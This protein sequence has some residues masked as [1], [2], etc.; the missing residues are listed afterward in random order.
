MTRPTAVATPVETAAEGRAVAGAVLSIDPPIVYTSLEWPDPMKWV[1][2]FGHTIG[3]RSAAILVY[4]SGHFNGGFPGKLLVTLLRH[5]RRTHPR[6]EVHILCNAPDEVEAFASVGETAMLL[7]HNLAVSNSMFR[8]LPEMETIFD[9]IY[10]ASLS[11]QKRIELAAKIDRVAYVT[12]IAKVPIEETHRILAHLAGLAP[13]HVIVN[14]WQD[15]APARLK[16]A[17]VNVACNRAAV[18]LC[19]SRIEGAM[20]SSMEYLLAGLPIVTTP[21]K[22]GRDL[23]FDPEYCLTVAPNPRAVREAVAALRQRRIKREYIHQ[24]SL[25]KLGPQRRAFLD[26]LDGILERQGYSPRFSGPW[27]WAHRRNFCGYK[28][29]AEH[30]AQASSEA[31]ARPAEAELD[32][33]P[34]SQP[35]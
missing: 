31:T 11:A 5:Y 27:P 21:S 6:H 30:F 26:L 33:L 10:T 15:G 22:G 18:G 20:L 16:A 9:A 7:N 34:R 13:A 12:Y 25:A 19:L 24:R 17:E 3:K 23:F 14:R 1:N 8:P 2:A 32:W 29:V 28:S 4:M 35:G